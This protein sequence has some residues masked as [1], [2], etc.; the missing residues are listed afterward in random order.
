MVCVCKG[1][2]EKGRGEKYIPNQMDL[3]HV[4]LWLMLSD[5]LMH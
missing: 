4:A 5:T 1:G 3:L 2:R